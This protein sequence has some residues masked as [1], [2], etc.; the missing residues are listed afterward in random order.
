MKTTHI[1]VTSGLSFLASSYHTT[2]H[3]LPI[4][5]FSNRHTNDQTPSP[6]IFSHAFMIPLLLCYRK[7]KFKLIALHVHCARTHKL[8]LSLSLHTLKSTKPPLHFHQTLLLASIAFSSIVRLYS[9]FNAQKLLLFQMHK[10]STK[11]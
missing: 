8:S 9:L 11:F 1:C 4:F 5:N 7:Y 10:T 6:L 3:L 2:L